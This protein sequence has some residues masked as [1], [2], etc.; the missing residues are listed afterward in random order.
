MEVRRCREAPR[1]R[2]LGPATKDAPCSLQGSFER[3]RLKRLQEKIRVKELKSKAD[4]KRRSAQFKAHLRQKFVDAARSYLG[5]PYG[6]RFHEEK[7]CECEGC[8]DAG[9]PLR[10]SDQ[11]LDCCALVRRCVHDLREDFGFELGGGNQ[12]YQFDTLP[13]R[14]AS[15]DEL[16]PGDLIFFSGEYFNPKCKRQIHDMTHVEI[17][18]GGDTGKAVIGSREKQKWIKEYDSYEFVSK[19]WKLKELFFVKIDTWLNG[20]C[21]SHC[22]DNAWTKYAKDGGKDSNRSIFYAADGSIQE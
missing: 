10:D 22:K 1:P 13:T 2:G 9:R 16:E 19:S 15:V 11:F 12:A 17:F 8:V 21:R 5:V 7:D 20:E 18:V 4:S 6:K 3:F 14:V